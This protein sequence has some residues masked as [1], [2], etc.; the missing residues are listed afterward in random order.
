MSQKIIQIASPQV[1]VGRLAERLT[2]LQGYIYLFNNTNVALTEP[3]K[4]SLISIH[5]D[6]LTKIIAELRT[7][8]DET[9][10][11]KPD[12]E[13]EKQLIASIEKVLGEQKERSKDL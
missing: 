6:G 8:I 10:K 5:L 13:L 4:I 9:L 7:S 3:E 11:T 2:W 12:T 1:L